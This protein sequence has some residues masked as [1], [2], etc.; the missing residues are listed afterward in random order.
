[1]KSILLFSFLSFY[2]IQANAQA[3]EKCN[4]A[5]NGN[6]TFGTSVTVHNGK[7]YA[8]NNANGIQ[9]SSDNGAT[10]AV[11]NPSIVTSQIQLYSTGDR[12]YAVLT[13]TGCSTIQYSTDD[14]ATFQLDTTGLPR[15][16]AGAVTMPSLGG[17][18]WTNHLLFSLAGPDWEFSRNTADGS[19]ID[20]SYFDANDCSEFYI[21]N[22]TCWA[23]TN[24]ATSNGTAWSVDGLNWTSPMTVGL[25]DYYVPS[26]IAFVNNRMFMMGA[27]VANG[28]A[29]SDTI[30]KYSDDYGLS[31]QDINIKQYLDGSPVFSVSG[32]QTTLD[33]YGAYGR[34]YLTLSNNM[35]G[36]SP[37][38]L[39]STDGGL[40]FQKDTVGLPEFLDGT[41][42]SINGM[43]FMN[44]W[45]FAQV[46]S[47]DLYRKQIGTVGLEEAAVQA[48]T[49]KFWPNPALDKIN[50]STAC[51]FTLANSLGARV[52]EV[53]NANTA[54]ISNLVPGV[55]FVSIWNANGLPIHQ[56]K[57]VKL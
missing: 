47:G 25:P 1:M 2:C 31:F 52:M 33:M 48:S 14:G 34:L 4:L 18:A 49:V 53:Q 28:A 21:K 57:F 56:A 32:K 8:T 46:N 29:G 26:Q 30:V 40:T 20:A 27:D 10:W 15:C 12:L 43:V 17:T 6:N 36:S 42:Y 9:V 50:F 35:F 54:D 37:D 5:T 16:Y 41:N 11:V 45:A 22:D 7:L 19:W 13:N 3:W 38:L 55:Y 39:V 51:H 23:A 44:G 24:G